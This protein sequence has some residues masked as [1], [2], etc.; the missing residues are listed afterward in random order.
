VALGR[1]KVNFSYDSECPLSFFGGNAQ[2]LHRALM[3]GQPLCSSALCCTAPA[4]FPN[5][6]CAAALDPSKP[7]QAGWAIQ[8]NAPA[9]WG[10]SLAAPRMPAKPPSSTLWSTAGTGGRHCQCC[11]LLWR[12]LSVAAACVAAAAAS[13]G[14]ILWHA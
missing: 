3:K 2:L 5:T 12:G 4:A 7:L 1:F 8:R 13:G 9:S 14:S 11:P 10:L 6:S